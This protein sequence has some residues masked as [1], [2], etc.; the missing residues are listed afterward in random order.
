[1]TKKIY[2]KDGKTLI[3]ELEFTIA[4]G[5]LTVLLTADDKTKVIPVMDFLGKLGYSDAVS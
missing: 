2:T 3:A 5:E 1:M 4:D